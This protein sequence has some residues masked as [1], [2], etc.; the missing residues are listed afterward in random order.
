MKVVRQVLATVRSL[1]L[2]CT[3]GERRA[4][5]IAAIVVMPALLVGAVW[6]PLAARVAYWERVL[7]KQHRALLTMR[8]EAITIRLLRRHIGSA[9]TGTAFVHFIEQSAQGAAIDEALSQFSPRGPQKAEADF[10]HV[11]F[12]GLV[13]FLA[14]LGR[15]GISPTRVE[16]T[17][18]DTGLVSGSVTL[19]AGA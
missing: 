5:M 13:R 2:A 15:H 14:V 6:V 19:V 17:Q 4:L 16:L 11:P 8:R 9:P 18:V 7:P 1:W 12:N 3:A 10:S